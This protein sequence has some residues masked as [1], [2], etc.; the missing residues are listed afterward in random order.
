MISSSGGV[1]RP[2]NDSIVR[3]VFSVRVS[4]G[5]QS[6]RRAPCP[7][8]PGPGTCGTGA[9]LSPSSVLSLNERRGLKRRGRRR[10]ER[11]R[12][13]KSPASSLSSSAVLVS[14][15][16]RVLGSP[17]PGLADWQIL[18]TRSIH[19]R[20][21]GRVWQACRLFPKTP[22]CICRCTPRCELTRWRRTAKG[23]LVARSGGSSGIR[24]VP[25]AH[26]LT[27]C[28]TAASRGLGSCCS[29]TCRLAQ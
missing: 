1:H 8:R 17:R 24:A 28:R 10:R 25:H 3:S 20:L 5:V 16:V 19:G 23:E 12:G 27:R 11:R 4:L 14:A 21:A 15:R 29:G 18:H 9:G 6:P 26:T 22:G 7:R 13:R 2:E